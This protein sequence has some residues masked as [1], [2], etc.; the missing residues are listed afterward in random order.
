MFASVHGHVDVMRLL[1]AHHADIQVVTKSGATVLGSARLGGS[2]AALRLVEEALSSSKLHEELFEKEAGVEA[3]ILSASFSGDAMLVHRLLRGG[4]SANTVSSGG[5][6]PLMLAAAGGSL[7]TLR[8]LV[9]MGADVNKQDADGWSALMFCAHA[10]NLPCM[11]VLLHAGADI[12]LTNAEGASVLQLTS[13]EGHVQAFN[14]IVSMTY[15]RELLLGHEEHL[16]AMH[17]AGVD[18]TAID[19]S[20]VRLPS[21]RDSEQTGEAGAAAGVSSL[22][23]EKVE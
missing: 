16:S 22:E 9:G 2:P 14:F 17:A 6:T 1:L 15:C 23:G 20:G 11:E 5:W 19:C 4:H 12:F 21:A 8:V 3:V 10:S 7:P 18:P 13:A